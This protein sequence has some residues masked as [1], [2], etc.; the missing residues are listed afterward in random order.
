MLVCLGSVEAL[1]WVFNSFE[2]ILWGSIWYL[3]IWVLSL[4]CMRIMYRFREVVLI[5][6]GKLLHPLTMCLV[7]RNG[8]NS[9]PCSIHPTW[10]FL[11]RRGRMRGERGGLYVQHSPRC[12]CVLFIHILFIFNFFYYVL[13]LFFLSQHPHRCPFIFLLFFIPCLAPTWL[14]P[15]LRMSFSS[16]KGTRHPWSDSI[17]LYC[18]SYSFVNIFKERLLRAIDEMHMLER[19]WMFA[20]KKIQISSRF[21]SV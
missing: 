20:C 1:N 17:P 15:A 11:P 13:H 4:C 2:L 7:C 9:W 5:A 8:K 19:T 21:L 16:Q 12:V 6:I 3:I 14:S 10:G 18:H